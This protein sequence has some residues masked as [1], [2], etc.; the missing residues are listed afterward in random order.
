[1]LQYVCK[2]NGHRAATCLLVPPV[3][4]SEFE[5][6]NTHLE[7]LDPDRGRIAALVVVRCKET[8]VCELYQRLRPHP[9]K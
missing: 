6:M 8:I 2:E 5:T 9:H 4:L 7:G 3:P 1:M